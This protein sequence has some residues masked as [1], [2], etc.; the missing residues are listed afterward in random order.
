M[1]TRIGIKTSVDAM[2][3][4]TFFTPPQQVRVLALSRRLGRRHRRDVELA[5]GRSIATPDAATG[6][7]N[8]NR[9]RY[10][11]QSVDDLTLKALATIDDK[12]R[13]K[14]CCSRRPRSP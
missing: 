3:A 11:N 2:T 1:L 5:G 4:S 13:E 8:T 9:G 14:P 10:S 12:Q 6:L 7:G